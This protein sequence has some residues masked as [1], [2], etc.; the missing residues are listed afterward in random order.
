MA[1][2]KFY[3]AVV[4]GQDNIGVI[5]SPTDTNELLG[6]ELDTDAIIIWHYMG[7]HVSNDD[8]VKKQVFLS[9]VR[10]ILTKTGAIVIIQ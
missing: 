2:S 3:L 1:E 10:N 8:E 6:E 5:V 7:Q 9:W 4:E